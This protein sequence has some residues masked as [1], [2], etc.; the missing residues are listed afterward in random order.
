MLARDG[1][2]SRRMASLDLLRLVAALA[3]VSFHYLFRGATADGFLDRGYPAA[4]PY[5]I[6]GYLGVDLFFLISGFVIAWSAEGRTWRDFAAARFARLYPGYLVCMTATFAVLWL[7]AD[8]RLPVTMLSYAANLT[9]V[10]PAFHQPFMDGVYWSIVLELAF[11]GWVALLIFAGVFQRWKLPL[12]ALWLAIAA[13]NEFFIGSGALRHLFLTEYAG[14]FTVGILAEHMVRKGGS[15]E[16]WLL[17]VAAFLLSCN[18]LRVTQGWMLAHYGVAPSFAGLLTANI[19]IHAVFAGA[20]MVR[21]LIAPSRAVL[22]LG[23][24]TY[25]L[26]LLHQNAGY[27]ALNALTPRVGAP[28]AL[29]LVLAG[30]LAL[31]FLVCRFIEQPLRK[32]LRQRALA[33]LDRLPVMRA[34]RPGGKRLITYRAAE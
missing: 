25:P 14:F 13:A 33:L 31:S 1:G 17:S 3:V 23:G 30:A 11:Y 34:A 29:G 2:T 32:P 7:A 21:G 9:M 20:I 8:P 18:T 15:A 26:Y 5:A 27:L 10:A 4:A 28:A 6:Y 16:C 24:L 19:V 22:L 12:A